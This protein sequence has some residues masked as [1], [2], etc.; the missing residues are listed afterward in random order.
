MNYL[1][2]CLLIGF[3]SIGSA[4]IG[5]LIKDV[6]IV[7]E[8]GRRELKQIEDERDDQIRR[9]IIRQI[10]REEMKKL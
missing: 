9:C 8:R 2:I 10:V 5:Y 4:M 3:A 6:L 7:I 1:S